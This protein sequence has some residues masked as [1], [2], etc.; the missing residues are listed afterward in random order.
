MAHYV[1]FTMR[2]VMTSFHV[3]VGMPSTTVPSKITN[4]MI[5]ILLAVRVT[6]L[7][8]SHASH[9][10]YILSFKLYHIIY[11]ISDKEITIVYMWHICCY[12]FNL[13]ALL[14]RINGKDKCWLGVFLNSIESL[15]WGEKIKNKI[16]DH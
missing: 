16:S 9:Y 10:I 4:H 7:I 8:S 5:C 15:N 13:H 1:A 12:M 14:L 6:H 3:W 2:K 11:L